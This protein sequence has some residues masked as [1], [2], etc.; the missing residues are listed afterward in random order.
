[1]KNTF[2]RLIFLAGA[3][4]ASSFAILPLP[5]P[6]D[7]D[8][9]ENEIWQ[10]PV[11]D[12][13]SIQGYFELYSESKLR[14]KE[15][16]H[17]ENQPNT[18]GYKENETFLVPEELRTRVEFWKKIYSEYTSF[19]AVLHDY[20]QPE[21]IYGVVDLSEFMNDRRLSY[22][23]QMKKISKYLKVEK[24]IIQKKLKALD[25]L[26]GRPLEI[27]L[28]LF[29]LFKKFES[30]KEERKF[31]KAAS[32]IRAQIGQ[33]DRIVKG[34]LYGGRYFNR[35][36]EIFEQKGLPK[37]LTR[38]PL[39]ESAFNLSA[40]SKVG[41]SGIWQFMRSTGK[42]FLRIDKS[43]DERN[44][45]LS[46]TRAAAELLRQNYDALKTWPLA[47]T[48]YNH[49]R[50]GMARA[51]RTLATQD[52]AEIIRRYKARTFGFASSNFY[53]EFLAILELEREYRT[54]FGKL[55]VDSPLR[56]E[57]IEIGKESR[58]QELA[59]ACRMPV[60]ELAVFNPALTDWVLTGR[61]RVPKGYA[62][63]VPPES[64]DR[65]RSGFRNVSIL[66]GFPRKG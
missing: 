45:P 52:L 39:V 20:E 44:D 46:A 24:E 7:P 27:P 62:L 33:R 43:I 31:K 66:R 59:D 3:W 30:V 4:S 15:L 50:E 5:Y 25:S 36:M 34:F 14:E 2:Y 28:E 60:R 63:K 51:V 18:L 22:R 32:R 10:Q 65:C 56:A 57:E 41:A 12:P 8:E 42:K 11:R 9:F 13:K 19:Q 55:M 40:R 16:P 35:M 29:P 38:L 54:H 47:I 26:D 61:G 37:E 21:I 48:A 6:I 64:A 53:S 58:F 23:Q 17:Y 1:M 49:G